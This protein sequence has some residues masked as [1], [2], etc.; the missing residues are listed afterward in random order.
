MLVVKDNTEIRFIYEQLLEHAGYH[1]LCAATGQQAR[2][3][4]ARQSIDGFLLDHRLPD[5]TGVDLCREFR[6]ALGPNV[7]IM[8]LTADHEAEAFAAGATV[9]LHK[10]FKPDVVLTLLAAYLPP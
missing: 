2:S 8:L 7:P 1:V 9:F 6:T 10:P 3:L 4:A 5:A